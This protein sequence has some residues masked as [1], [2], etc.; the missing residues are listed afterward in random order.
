MFLA[1]TLTLSMAAQLALLFGL[2]VS[3]HVLFAVIAAA[4]AT[5]V[6]SFAVL[7]QYFPKEVSG[8]ANAALGVLNMGTAFSLQCLSGFI[9]A[10]WPAD[11]GR[12][13]AEAHRPAMAA[14]LALQLVA[15]GVFCTPMRRP[16]PTP[17]AVAVS[18]SLGYSMTASAPGYTAEVTA[19]TQ[20][21]RLFRTYA[22]G[23]RLA[24]CAATM[25]C[26]ALSTLL[27]TAVDRAAVALYVA[28]IDH[29]AKLPAAGSPLKLI[30]PILPPVV[31]AAAFSAPSLPRSGIRGSMAS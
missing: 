14:G 6:L 17:M 19:R 1:G 21:V 29:V 28:D 7:A 20:H 11:A 10:L 24:A 2:P 13:P 26:A 9:V 25:L 27:S 30:E 22:A 31:Q 4:G 18:R 15:L 12:Y 8:R 23:W 5:T 3:S 16:R